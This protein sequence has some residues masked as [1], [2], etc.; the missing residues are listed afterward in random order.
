VKGVRRNTDKGGC[1]LCLCEDDAKHILLDCRETTNWRLKFLKDKSLNTN[2]VAYRKMLRRTNKDQI[3]LGR[4]LDTVKC[5]W[6]NKT[7]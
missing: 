4:Y 1:P 3:N 2:K 6:C 5:K 7:K